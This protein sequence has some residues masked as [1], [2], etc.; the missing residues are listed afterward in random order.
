MGAWILA[1]CVLG[2]AVGA[3]LAFVQNSRESA[4]APVSTQPA[5]PVAAW[6]AGAKPAPAFAL[7]DEAGAPISLRQF[8]GRPVIVTFIDPVCRSLC[9]LEAKQLNAVVTSSPKGQR[10]TVVAISVNP[11][12]QSRAAFRQDD[13]KWLNA[14]HRSIGAVELF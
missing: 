14:I 4:Q 10:P 1:V 11:W 8:R 3:V 6:P 13:R 5:A 2:I 9:P 7:D 12:A